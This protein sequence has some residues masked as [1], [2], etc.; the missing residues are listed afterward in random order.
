MALEIKLPCA[1]GDKVYRKM[2]LVGRDQVIE[3]IVKSIHLTESGWFVWY[4]KGSTRTTRQARLSEVGRTIF[5]TREEAWE[6][7][8]CDGCE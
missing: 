2:R 5:L 7:G 1:V 4:S 3:F 6:S 8:D